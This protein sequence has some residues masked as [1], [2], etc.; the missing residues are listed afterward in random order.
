MNYKADY[1]ETICTRRMGEMEQG[2]RVWVWV[3]ALKSFDMEFRHRARRG[4]SFVYEM[5]SYFGRGFPN[6]IALPEYD[7][8]SDLR[9]VFVHRWRL[10][11]SASENGIEIVTILHGARLIEVGV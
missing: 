1:F 2:N 5:F 7:G 6:A 4:A 8:P 3:V 9:E 10:I 11:Y